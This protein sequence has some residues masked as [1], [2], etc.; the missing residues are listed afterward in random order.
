MDTNI[1]DSP[2]DYK[3]WYQF[4]TELLIVLHRQGN[5]SLSSSFFR[6]PCSSQLR[7]VVNYCEDDGQ[8]LYSSVLWEALE[9]G[10]TKNI[11]ITYA[12]Q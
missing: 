4:F 10:K 3:Y 11:K 8:A 12:S 5:F 7:E 9:H 2:L 1:L 6:T